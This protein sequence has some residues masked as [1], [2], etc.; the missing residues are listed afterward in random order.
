VTG[1][2]NL[3]LEALSAYEVEMRLSP[4]SRSIENVIN[5]AKI[6]GNTVGV[7]YAEAFILI[8]VIK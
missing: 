3:K 2:I 6:R 7:E 1:C 4:H 8:R 5:L